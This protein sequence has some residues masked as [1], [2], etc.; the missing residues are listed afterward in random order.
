ME[1]ICIS[2]NINSGNVVTP[3]NLYHFE[4]HEAAY[5]KI[6]QLVLQSKEERNE[7]IDSFKTGIL[8]DLKVKMKVPGKIICAVMRKGIKQKMIE[9]RKYFDNI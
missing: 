5:D 8:R 9:F 1:N 4:T 7:E 3:D 6:F 2:L